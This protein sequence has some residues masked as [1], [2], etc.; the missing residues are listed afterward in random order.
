MHVVSLL[1][2][3][4]VHPSALNADY[5]KPDIAVSGVSCR[6]RLPVQGRHHRQCPQE[7]PLTGTLTDSTRSLRNMQNSLFCPIRLTHSF[8]CEPQKEKGDAASHY[9]A[10]LL[11]L[12]AAVGSGKWPSSRRLSPTVDVSFFCHITT[13]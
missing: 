2:R 8:A 10:R 5:D 4:Y 13:H 3:D 12:A 9:A 6:A 11:K 1:F 7:I